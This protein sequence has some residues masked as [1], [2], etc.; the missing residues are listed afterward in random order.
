MRKVEQEFSP[1]VQ[2]SRVKEIEE[3]GGSSSLQNALNC[4]W[5]CLPKWFSRCSS[6]S[7]L[8]NFY[9]QREIRCHEL[10]E[11][12]NR[13]KEYI[14]KLDL[15]IAQRPNLAMQCCEMMQNHPEHIAYI[16][17]SDVV[18]SPSMKETAEEDLIDREER[19]GIE[20][21][22]QEHELS[23]RIRFLESHQ[24]IWEAFKKEVQQ[25][26]NKNDQYLLKY[27]N[28]QRQKRD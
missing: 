25:A 14:R 2:E 18:P 20:L 9:G 19:L 27:L 4:C 7:S 3:K 5:K 28:A 21:V 17:E 1:L 16:K 11:S 26:E 8:E 24:E 10:N 23:E 22:C 13:T 6:T 15:F 12:I